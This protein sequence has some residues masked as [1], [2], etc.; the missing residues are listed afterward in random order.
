MPSK[1]LASVW[2][3][4]K[5]IPELKKRNASNT[6]LNDGTVL[7]FLVALFK[8]IYK[9]YIQC[10]RNS[11][12]YQISCYNFNGLDT[13][14]AKETLIKQ[15]NDCLYSYSIDK[16][17]PWVIDA[18]DKRFI[19]IIRKRALENEEKLSIY[20]D[21]FL[22]SELAKKSIPYAKLKKTRQYLYEIATLACF[23]CCYDNKLLIFENLKY[24]D[25]IT[26]FKKLLNE[27]CRI[28]QLKISKLKILQKKIANSDLLAVICSE[29]YQKNL[30]G[31]ATYWEKIESSL[32]KN[33]LFKFINTIWN[34]T[35]SYTTLLRWISFLLIIFS[36]P[37][38]NFPLILFIAIP[39]IRYIIFCFTSFTAL[40][41][42]STFSNVLEIPKKEK[43][44]SHIKQEVFNK[45]QYEKQLSILQNQLLHLDI[46]I[47][48]L[49]TN[50]PLQ[51]SKALDTC[52]EFESSAIYQKL[53]RVFP[54]TQFITS[55]VTKIM[56][57]TL[58]AYLISWAASIFFNFIG[59]LTLASLISS[60]LVVGL[61]ILIP[62]CIFLIRHVIKYQSSKNTYQRTIRT[63]LKEPCEFS[64]IDNQGELKTVTLE[65]W[66]KFELL[67]NEIRALEL[68][69]KQFRESNQLPQESKKLFLLFNDYL[70]YNDI[71]KSNYQDKRQRAI[72][73]SSAKIKKF[74][75]RLLSFSVGGFYG[76]SLGE[77]IAF[78]SSLGFKNFFSPSPYILFFTPLIIIHGT[79]NFLTYH[80]NS[81]QRNLLFFAE[82]LDS[83]LQILEY[84]RKILSYLTAIFKELDSNVINTSCTEKVTDVSTEKQLAYLD[85]AVKK[86]NS[87]ERRPNC[88][89]F[90]LP[91]SSLTPLL[92]NKTDL[93]PNLTR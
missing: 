32:N 29:N 58:S 35:N 52:I 31:A 76:F 9:A 18:R 84:R 12:N 75:S 38:P 44:L 5:K 80:L 46:K 50:L 23:K 92:I 63:L 93:R 90:T 66:Q 20:I 43:I 41:K 47:E 17:N 25:A 77:Q 67:R 42:I 27:D 37:F 8:D 3:N 70:K 1:D 6:Q 15:Y 28:V 51:T 54:K 83:K 56:S 49:Y 16:T 34:A 2:N 36:I 45:A 78:E 81:R 4:L 62:T 7:P 48:N 82:H 13:H 69:I 73:S 33:T 19:K 79:A 89:F 55:L 85:L 11:W 40:N 71:Y 22:N 65:K 26:E 10:D 68:K 72:I 86:I 91:T 24:Q 14:K 21:Q 60:P 57:V 61:F 74:L 64:F 53:N 87:N 39:S 59:A 30:A 88:K